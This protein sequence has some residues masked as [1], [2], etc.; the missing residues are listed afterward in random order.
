MLQPL[1]RQLTLD[2]L[3]SLQED[4][5]VNPS[6]QQDLEKERRTSATCGPVCLESYERLSPGMSW[7]KTFVGYLVG[8]GDWYSSKCALTWKL[9]GTKLHRYYFQLL[10]KTLPIEEIASG[11]LPTPM[12]QSRQAT[13]EQTLKRKEK[14]GGMKRAMYL[15]NYLALGMLPTPT[16]ADGRGPGVNSNTTT[17]ENGRFVRTSKT[18]GTKF[19]ASIGMA[20]SFINQ[21]AGKT[22][23]LN[24][25][26]VEEMMG[27]PKNWTLS[28]FQSGEMKV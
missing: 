18:T 4:S 13:K 26:F 6:A 12:A 28:P 16:C 1:T 24:P 19:G 3:I 22:S 21:E 2:E 8:Q 27:F 15:E 23:Q 10:P 14:Y 9:K 7:G 17:L 11:L 20:V 25:Q 5:H